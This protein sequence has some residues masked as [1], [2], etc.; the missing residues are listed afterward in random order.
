MISKTT[1]KFWKAYAK[2]D[3]TVQQQARS[4]Y[5][6]FRENPQHPSLNFKKVHDSLPIYSAR[7]NLSHRAVGILEKNEIIW[8]WIG[9]HDAYENLLSRL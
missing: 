7:V 9:P 5:R 4:S 3:R 6:L 1:K 2:L 8:F